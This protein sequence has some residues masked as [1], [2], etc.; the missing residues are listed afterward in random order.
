MKV[1]KVNLIEFNPYPVEYGCNN[2][3]YPLF[4]IVTTDGCL[5][6]L[7][8]RCGKGCSNTSLLPQEGMEF[9]NI[10]DLREYMD[11]SDIEIV[12]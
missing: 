9:D 2:G 6:T 1:L 4:E 3:N 11:D 5:T 10:E 7:S 12:E 8:C